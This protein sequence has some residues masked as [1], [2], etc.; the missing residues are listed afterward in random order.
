MEIHPITQLNRVVRGG[1]EGG[2]T[3]QS[4][5][6]T[7]YPPNLEPCHKSEVNQEEKTKYILTHTCAI[8]KNGA[9]EPMCRA[10]L[11]MQM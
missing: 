6:R 11:E 4:P 10:G 3:G 5:L 2:G 9:D 7:A 1:G 8:S